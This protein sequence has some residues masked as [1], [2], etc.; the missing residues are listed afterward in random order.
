M[1]YEGYPVHLLGNT[2]NLDA[3]TLGSSRYELLTS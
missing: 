2:L 3:V 1:L